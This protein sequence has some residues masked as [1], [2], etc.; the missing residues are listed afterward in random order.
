MRIA[1][2]ADLHYQIG[3]LE[4]FKPIFREME[5]QA[6][7]LV[8]AGDLTN[9][10]LPE[11][12]RLLIDD[13]EGVA[14]PVLAVLGNHDHEAGHANVLAAMLH[15]AGVLM[16]DR[17]EIDLGNVG[18]V[19]TKGFCGGFSKRLVQPF[20]EKSLKVFIRTSM[21]EAMDLENAAAQLKSSRKVGILHYAPI[22]ATLQGESEELFPFLG[23][24]RLADALDHQQVKLI[25]HGHAHYGSPEG[26][27]PGG[28]RVYN[29]ARFVLQAHY[30]RQY[31]L[32]DL[33]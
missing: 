26:H 25:L 8:L 33:S 6:D 24:S 1:A 29:V 5:Q 16:L 18:F 7:V 3:N 9:D 32:I 11:E 28:A 14:V 31:R 19:G 21:D 12:A 27:T 30:N 20:G 13:L 4:S 23:T 15:E 17:T 10:G 22:R 2:I